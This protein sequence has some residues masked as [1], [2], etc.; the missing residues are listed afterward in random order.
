MALALRMLQ[1]ANNASW[2]VGQQGPTTGTHH[3]VGGPRLP[4]IA[5]E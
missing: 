2:L 5:R 3:T 4:Q 1:L